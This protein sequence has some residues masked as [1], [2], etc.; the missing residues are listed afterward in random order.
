MFHILAYTVNAGVN[1]ANVDMAAVNDIIFTRRGGAGGADHF[2]FTEQ[3]H[4][5]RWFHAAANATRARLNAPTLNILSRHQVW[6]V[7]RSATIPDRPGYQDLRTVPMPLPI[8]E[9]I[10]VEESNNLGAGNERTNS[11]LTIAP[12]NWSMTLPRAGAVAGGSPAEI[13][14]RFT[15][16]IVVSA[17]AWSAPVNLTFSDGLKGG[18]YTV[19]G[20]QCQ[21][22]SDLAFRLFFPRSP[23]GSNQRQLRPGGLMQ[24]GVGDTPDPANMGGWGRWGFF[25]S[26]EPP[27]LEVFALAAGATAIEGR[28][29]LLYHDN[30][31]PF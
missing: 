30:V 25:H 3:Y 27:Q 22:T 5:L 2:I 16:T 26:F 13:V 6:P 15:A 28:L 12:P 4:L 9:E 18:W 1:D 7:E 23:Y 20:A 21:G 8:D 11:F 14:A 19:L 29:M 31:R 24:D 17:N 10:A